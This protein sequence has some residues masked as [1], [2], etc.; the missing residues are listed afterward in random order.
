[1]ARSAPLGFFC[2]VAWVAGVM[3]WRITFVVAQGGLAVLVCL[4]RVAAMRWGR[5]VA[6][7][8]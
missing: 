6:G 7:A 4:A 3:F 5:R 8:S 1:M 2:L